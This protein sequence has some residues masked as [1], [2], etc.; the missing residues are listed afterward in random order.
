MS[1]VSAWAEKA[2]LFKIYFGTKVILME[3]ISTANAVVK[4]I[5]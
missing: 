2:A 5:Q 1:F 3:M 4:P